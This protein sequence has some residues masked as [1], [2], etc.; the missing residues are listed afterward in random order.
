MLLLT[1]T[2]I[3]CTW[4]IPDAPS[5]LPE[6]KFTQAI[7]F[8]SEKHKVAIIADTYAGLTFSV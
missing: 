5:V 8:L 1:P 7:Q 3:L 2:A 4:Q 6:N